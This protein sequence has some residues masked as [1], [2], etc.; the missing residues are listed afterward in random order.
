MIRQL[1][2]HLVLAI[3]ACFAVSSATLAQSTLDVVKERGKVVAGVRFDTPPYGYL[4]EGGNLVGLDIDIANYIS[5]KLGVD[6]EF[7]QVTGQTRIPMLE[8]GRV[9]M[10][11][12]A[13]SIF[14]KRTEVVD[15]TVPY[16][17]DGGKVMVPK[18]SKIRSF[19]DL[20][21]SRV[22]TVQGTPWEELVLKAHPTAKVLSYQ[23]YPQALLAMKQGLAD[24][25]VTDSVVLAGLAGGDPEIEIV[26]DFFTL[27]PLAIGVR[28]ND[29]KWRNALTFLLQD[30]WTEGRYR[31]VY[32]SHFGPSSK[33]PL[34]LGFKIETWPE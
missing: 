14:R 15:F 3:L 21:N 29:A 8:S 4:D 11:V 16:F 5:K 26:G 24:A 25:V 23:E 33:Y 17:Y 20:G 13:L 31:E 12:S 34:P 1:L 6:V 32:E 9:D 28:H 18:G 2:R 7:V 19:Q 22:A 10:L 27:A 30:M